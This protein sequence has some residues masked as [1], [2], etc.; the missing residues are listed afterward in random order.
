[1]AAEFFDPGQETAALLTFKPVPDY[2]PA[3][4]QIEVVGDK[5]K[6]AYVSITGSHTPENS[7]VVTINSPDGPE[8][9]EPATMLWQVADGVT[10]KSRFSKQEHAGRATARIITSHL[11]KIFQEEL[12]KTH[13]IKFELK[14]TLT[15]EHT[16]NPK[17]LLQWLSDNVTDESAFYF[18]ML[19]NYSEHFLRPELPWDFISSSE[20]FSRLRQFSPQQMAEYLF[21]DDYEQDPLFIFLIAFYQTLDRGAEDFK[22]EFLQRAVNRTIAVALTAFL[23]SI[24]DGSETKKNFSELAVNK[25]VS[26]VGLTT[27]T[28]IIE[29]P[30]EL[31]LIGLGDACSRLFDIDGNVLAKTDE[32]SYLENV[33]GQAA[34][35]TEITKKVKRID[36]FGYTME[37]DGKVSIR[38]PRGISIQR[39]PKSEFV[40]AIAASS[41]DGMLFPDG[42][43]PIQRAIIE[44]PEVEKEEAI[45]QLGVQ[46]TAEYEQSAYIDCDDKSA[47]LMVIHTI[48]HPE[49]NILPH[50]VAAPSRKQEARVKKK[51]AA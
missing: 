3:S 31:I 45:L 17:N 22:R 38:Y 32:Q 26:L 27:L 1:M 21:I 5:R 46:K 24:Q 18:Y 50:T 11:P 9:G 44:N 29:T 49:K 35:G 12:K 41:S 47:T 36:Y 43:D 10:T 25:H 42:Y 8:A 37:L 6:V 23:Q 20:G 2:P 28:L 34:D 16:Q 15:S 51:I 30:T 14:K 13:E 48:D 4:A 33:K 7:D 40:K 39:V 19:Q